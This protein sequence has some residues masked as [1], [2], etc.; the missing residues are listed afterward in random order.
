MTAFCFSFRQPRT[1][2]LGALVLG[3]LVFPGAPVLAQGADM[4]ILLD[5]MERLERDIRTLN[6]QIARGP[7][8]AAVQAGDGAGA[9]VSPAAP[10]GAA[11]SRPAVQ[12]TEGEGALS[13][14]TVR[15]SALEREVRQATGQ[16]EGMSYRIDQISL[17]LDKLVAD[18]DY[19]LARLEGRAPGG[20]SS[21]PSLSTVPP[22]QSVSKVGEMAAP[23]AGAAANGTLA[24]GAM[25]ENGT[26]IPPESGGGT[27]GRVSKSTLD[28]FVPT[29][30]A[31]GQERAALAAPT[32]PSP[33]TAADTAPAPVLAPAPAPAPASSSVLPAGTPR[34]RYQFAFGLMS[35]ARYE[36]AEI[37]LKEFIAA[38]GDDPLAGN[39]RYWLG[40]AY[41][42][43]KSFMDAAQ[44]FFQ[45]YKSTPDGAK[46]ADSL[47]KLGMSMANLDKTEE[48]CATFG[49][50]RKEF[51]ELKPGIEKT[52]NRE[53][54][55]LKCQ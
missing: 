12:F 7:S 48:A 36:E 26:Y 51:A 55:R 31:G 28:Q 54:T 52:L 13:R 23:T 10:I 49:K 9:P 42:V 27:L 37:A 3:A 30:N 40:E 15:L 39:A 33:A 21:E 43:R 25:G 2:L 6:R 4:Q 17:R 5:R 53:T 29:E 16:T 8:A 41:Y 1:T 19:R 32:S 18:L 45:A 35:Q 34:E 20:F 24:G 46:A 50:L 11:P 38:H 22:S 44:T 47:L 14:V